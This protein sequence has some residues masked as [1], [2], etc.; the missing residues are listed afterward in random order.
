[1]TAIEKKSVKKVENR[2]KLPLRLG[3][4]A[5]AFIIPGT[6]YWADVARNYSEEQSAVPDIK[7]IAQPADSKNA[8]KA[9]V[10]LDGFNRV[11]AD[12]YALTMTDFIQHYA[13]GELWSIQY[14]NAPLN[15]ET[16]YKSVL[17]L[18]EKRNI[19]TVSI[20]TYS[21]GDGPG[22]EV[23]T[24]I[25]TDS[26]LELETVS[27]NLGP[28]GYE[29]VRPQMQ[30][31]HDFANFIATWVPSLAYST[32]GRYGLEYW[33]YR[34]TFMKDGFDFHKFLRLKNQIEHRFSN[35]EY[36]TNSFLLSQI[37][38]L[39][40][41]R[42]KENIETIGKN[43][44]KKKL[45]NFIYFGV[46]EGGYD[47]IVDVDYSMKKIGSY[48]TKAGMR[49]FTHEVPG[50]AHAEYYRSVDEYMKAA[51]TI[52]RQ[53]EYVDRFAL[54][55]LTSDVAASQS[56]QQAMSTPPPEE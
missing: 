31:E 33:F 43:P 32:F 51:Q 3:T 4:A 20:A 25:F 42:I 26:P 29:G 15:G 18:A 1:L 45:P 5:M 30:S 17:D 49:Y 23:A 7:V 35:G 54:A 37:N 48:V 41:S 22:L 13:D 28:D 11:N 44:K 53:Q 36:T 9:T 39:S 10:I 6:P 21:M 27:I 34:D 8:H 19:T 2:Y 55:P 40:H 38:A 14:N 46:G 56:E 12:A 52:V 47:S 24:D 50:V 16:L